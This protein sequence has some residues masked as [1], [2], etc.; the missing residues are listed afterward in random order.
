MA[1][2]VIFWGSGFFIV[3]RCHELTISR[4]PWIYAWVG[5]TKFP[6]T[7]VR[8]AARRFGEPGVSRAAAGHT[9]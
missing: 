5:C 1:Y 4:I 7:Q 9:K 3:K 8:E 6:K 2:L